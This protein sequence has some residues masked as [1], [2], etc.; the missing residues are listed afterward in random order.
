VIL[1]RSGL[2]RRSR[3]EPLEPVNRYEH[4]RPGELADEQGATAA[5]FLARATAH[6]ANRGVRIERVSYRERV[7]TAAI[8]STADLR[9]LET[10]RVGSSEVVYAF[11]SLVGEPSGVDEALLDDKERLRSRRF[12]RSADCSRFVL[13]HA[14]LR[15]LLAG[16]LGVEPASVRYVSGVHGKPRLAPGLVPL[17]F[18]LSHSEGVA[19]VA[20]A[21]DRAVG[22]D[23]EH[24]RDMP[25]AL[26]IAATH[27]SAAE[28]AELRALSSADRRAGFF[29]CWTR[30]EAVI[31][32]SGEGL[33]RALDSFDVD[34][35]PGST[36][37]LRRYAGE[38]GS[39]TD[40]IVRDLPS[41]PGYAAAGA[42]AAPESAGIRWRE[43][44]IGV[45]R[46]ASP[47]R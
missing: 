46:A 16:A 8:W 44:A 43:L 21:R 27:F 40:M 3:L 42:V 19:L 9:D 23:V 22:V 33:S 36:S 26:N 15:L 11:V 2:G 5:A 35:A 39:G 29:Y 25:D 12:L 28:R 41:P 37:A 30:K 24:V 6:F 18:N 4:Q 7:H 32:T 47:E 1:R 20:V 17:E 14:A 10:I 45:E 13:A 34:L 31:K 38:H